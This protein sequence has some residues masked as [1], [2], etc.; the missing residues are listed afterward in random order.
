MDL[1]LFRTGSKFK[2]DGGISMKAG[3]EVQTFDGELEDLANNYIRTLGP[4]ANPLLG[5]FTTNSFK[6]E[7]S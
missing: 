3:K 5:V 2:G 1:T 7:I 6:K 4:D